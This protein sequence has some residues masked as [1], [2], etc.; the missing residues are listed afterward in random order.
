METP[1]T[2]LVILGPTATGKTETAIAV[3][4]ELGGEVVSADSRLVYRGMDIGTAKPTPAQR[5]EVPHHL[6]DLRDPDQTYHVAAF[7]RDALAALADIAARGRL[8]VV[9]GGTGLYL[10][11]LIRGYRFPPGGAKKELRRDLAA[12]PTERLHQRLAAVDPAAARRIGPRDRV[13]LVRALE[14]GGTPKLAPEPAPEWEFR[15]FGLMLPR[16][17]LYRRIEARVDAML[18]AGLEREVRAL[19]ARYDRHLP[20]LETLGYRELAEWLAGEVDREEA[21]RRIKT[22]TR[23]FAKRQLT[24]FRRE[25]S[26]TWVAAGPEAAAEIIRRA[27]GKRPGSENI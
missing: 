13:R 14:T 7:Q 22:R 3:A 4:R 9:A 10:R 27:A 6:I 20:A 19:L 8:P 2:A 21:V 5:R 17:E 26:V 18:A 11:A 1:R 15:V 25:E 12:W 16:A 23:R 24:W